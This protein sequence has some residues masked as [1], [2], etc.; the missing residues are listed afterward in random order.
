M[1]PQRHASERTYNPFETPNAP[2]TDTSR[3]PSG[4]TVAV[5]SGETTAEIGHE[6]GS[7]EAGLDHT[8]FGSASTFK[9]LL[10][11]HGIDPRD[12]YVRIRKGNPEKD[13][14]EWAWYS[15]VWASAD[16]MVV[17]GNNPI[18]GVYSVPAMR[19]EEEGYASYMGL[20]GDGEAVA[21][22]YEDIIQTAQFV[23]GRN[24]KR[25]EFV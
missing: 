5:D 9:S 22:L 21:A 17:T 3:L 12:G 24:P 18:T 20:E 15:Y 4:V 7:T 2:A 13:D 16:V 19:N 8:D 14:E 10:K 11:R 1:T 6:G 23:K 25:R